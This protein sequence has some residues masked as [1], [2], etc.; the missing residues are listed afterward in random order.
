MVRLF[1][2][3]VCFF[4]SSRRRHTRFSGV[5][6]F[7]RV[8]F[9]SGQPMQASQPHDE[10]PRPESDRGYRGDQIGRASCRERV[11]QYV[12]VSAVAVSLKKKKKKKKKTKNK[13]IRKKKKQNNKPK[14]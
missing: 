14:T 11:W 13:K 6:G 12:W 5:T 1:F 7:R 4:C 8:L 3:V 2:C 9:R 10:V